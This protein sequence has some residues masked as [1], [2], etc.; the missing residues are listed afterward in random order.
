M[1]KKMTDETIS[2]DTIHAIHDAIGESGN[3]PLLRHFAERESALTA[4]ILC[5]AFQ[6]AEHL[7]I[8]DV[9]P[10]LVTWVSDEVTARLLVALHAQYLAQRK[11]WNDFLP[12]ETH[13]KPSSEK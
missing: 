11:L 10:S 9:R 6:I 2:A 13:G 5:S 4:Y 3:D 8:A 1:A 12:D 7:R